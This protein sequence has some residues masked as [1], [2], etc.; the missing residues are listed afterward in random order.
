MALITGPEFISAILRGVNFVVVLFCRVYLPSL[1]VNDRINSIL[2]LIMQLAF[3]RGGGCKKWTQGM[4]AVGLMRYCSD[5]LGQ[6]DFF[7]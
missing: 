1:L 5:H 7:I 2:T 3:R 6:K 4:A